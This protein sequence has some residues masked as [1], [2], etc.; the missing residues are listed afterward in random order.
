MTRGGYRAGKSTGRSKDANHAKI[1]SILTSV[2]ERDDTSS[3]PTTPAD[4]TPIIPK[5]SRILPNQSRLTGQNMNAQSNT[6]AE[7]T[8]SQRNVSALGD[9][10]C[11]NAWTLI[12]MTS[13]GLEPS[14]K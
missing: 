14:S 12:F 11:N 3:I 7:A 2:I 8:S 10:S 1:S 9:S 5:I 13:S 4:Q 6:A